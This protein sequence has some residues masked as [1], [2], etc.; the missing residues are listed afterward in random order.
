[1]LSVRCPAPHNLELKMTDATQTEDLPVVKGQRG[2]KGLEAGSKLT[3]L[4]EGNPKRAGSKAYERFKLY[5]D[6]DTVG[7]FLRL[8]GT[9]A[10]LH[11]DTQHGFISIEGFTPKALPAK[12]EAD[13]A[14]P[15][16]AAK[17]ATTKGKGKKA[18]AEPAEAPESADA[19]AVEE[20]A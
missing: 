5:S 13:P 14:A 12:P 16:P 6:V 20:Q 17:K 3:V 2:P 9:T 8:G 15:A 10:D 7:E 4:V 1:M 18:K 19:N 11:Y